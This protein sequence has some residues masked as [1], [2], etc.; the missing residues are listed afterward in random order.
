MRENV[1]MIFSLALLQALIAGVATGDRLTQT[2]NGEKRNVLFNSR[3]LAG[4]TSK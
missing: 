3:H 4:G 2:I 1:T